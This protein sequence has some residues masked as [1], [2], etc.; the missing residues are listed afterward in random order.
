[1]AGRWHLNERRKIQRSLQIY[2]KTGKPASQIYA[3]QRERR[4]SAM[5]KANSGAATDPNTGL[6]F[7]TLLLWVHAP[8][9]VLNPRLDARIEKML[10][11]GLLSEVQ[12][13]A[14]FRESREA[15]TGQPVDQSRGIW[16]SIGY[17]EFLAY[18]A[19]LSTAPDATQN[20]EK[21]KQASVE[22]T[23]AATRQYAKRQVRWISIKLLNALFGAGQKAKTF[24]LDGSDL[25]EWEESV[26]QPSR[27]ITQRFLSGEPLPAPSETS[28]LANEMLVPKRDYDLSHRPDLWKQRTCEPCG[29]T[30]VNENDW[31]LHLKGRGH[32]RVIGVK[33]K[34]AHAQL[35]GP[36]TRKVPQADLVDIL[37]SYTQDLHQKSTPKGG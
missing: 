12:E 31:N 20:L 32:R 24:V 26:I 8:K 22:K 10:D 36:R 2:L 25:S 5:K 19:A 14:E 33:K 37:E 35:E 7:P 4:E 16:V 29:A 6:R 30:F 34:E 3:E 9:D 21:L 11:S 15:H 27:D 1:M 18:Q 13:L 28:A 23:Q 17:K